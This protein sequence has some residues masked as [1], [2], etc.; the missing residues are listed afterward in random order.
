MLTV[1]RE[2]I[3][4]SLLNLPENTTIEDAMERLYLL[5]KIEQGIIQAD[6]GLCISH[7][8][9]KEKMKIWLK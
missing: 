2:K 5:A 7:E 8:E 3:I 1:N 4:D 6:A 9:A